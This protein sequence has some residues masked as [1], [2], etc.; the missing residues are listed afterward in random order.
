MHY[1]QK[2]IYIQKGTIMR[3]TYKNFRI[4]ADSAA[5][6]FTLDWVPFSAA[7]LKIITNE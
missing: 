5:D 2:S 3:D 4:V 6:L 7:P 1:I